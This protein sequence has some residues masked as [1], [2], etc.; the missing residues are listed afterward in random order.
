MVFER[1][2]KPAK[3]D[4]MKLSKRCSYVYWNANIIRIIESL[5][6]KAQRAVLFNASTG[7]WFRTTVESDKGVYSHQPSLTSF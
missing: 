2:I 7:D 5:Y 3:I 4:G 6:D 1:R